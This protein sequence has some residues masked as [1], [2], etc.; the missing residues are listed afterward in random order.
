M[1]HISY[2]KV[3]SKKVVPQKRVTL[4]PPY[5]VFLFHQLDSSLFH[6]LYIVGGVDTMYVG[7]IWMFLLIRHLYLIGVWSSKDQEQTPYRYMFRNHLSE[8]SWE[9]Q[10]PN[11]KNSIS[12][13]I[14][15]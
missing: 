12:L 4:H 2:V 7:V 3:I 10:V 6:L 14:A 13:I 15:R 1:N 5:W 8:Y 11:S 9:R